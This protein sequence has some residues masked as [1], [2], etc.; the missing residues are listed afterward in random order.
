MGFFRE[1]EFFAKHILPFLKA[2]VTDIGRIKEL[3]TDLLLKFLTNGVAK[4][5]SRAFFGAVG[6]IGAKLEYLTNSTFVAAVANPISPILITFSRA[7][8]NFPGYS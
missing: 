8:A 5:A 7:G 6:L 3:V 2:A 4:L 1:I